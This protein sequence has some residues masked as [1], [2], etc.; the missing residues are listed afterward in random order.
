MLQKEESEQKDLRIVPKRKL[1]EAEKQII[2]IRI[3]YMRLQRENSM[4]VLAGSIVLFL[5][6]MVVSIIGL[7]NEII[8][9]SQLNLLVLSGLIVLIVGITP[10]IMFVAKQ[11]KSL[12]KTLE[13]LI[14]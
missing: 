13:D 7:L 11:Q 2:T 1:S 3:E 6:F 8:S 4:L 9:R 12:E 5:A 10:Y 14:S